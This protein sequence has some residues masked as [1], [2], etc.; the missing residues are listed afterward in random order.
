MLMKCICFISFLLKAWLLLLF[1]AWCVRESFCTWELPWFGS[2]KSQT[3]PTHCFLLLRQ[4]SVP[5]TDQLGFNEGVVDSI[6][7]NHH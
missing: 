7:P 1:Y 5:D 6:S 3:F 4:S 2:T